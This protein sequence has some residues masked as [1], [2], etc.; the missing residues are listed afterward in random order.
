MTNFIA[1]MELPEE[2]VAAL[3][4]IAEENNMTADQYA[5]NIV[6]NFIKKTYPFLL[7]N[8]SN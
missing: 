8:K 4:Q 3:V 7:T 2:Y 5:R 6:A 1:N